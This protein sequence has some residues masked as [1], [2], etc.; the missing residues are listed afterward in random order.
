MKILGTLKKEKK[1]FYWFF[2]GGGFFWGLSVSRRNELNGTE[3]IREGGF[4]FFSFSWEM[5]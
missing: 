5:N 2:F 4:F 3:L 1:Q